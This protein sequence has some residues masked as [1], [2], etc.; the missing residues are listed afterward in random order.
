V[1]A[2]AVP[3]PD[4]TVSRSATEPALVCGR[5]GS[6]SAPGR[7]FWCATC[8]RQ[9]TFSYERTPNRRLRD[10]V[11]GGRSQSGIWSW[12]DLLPAVGSSAITLGEGDTPLLPSR[13]AGPALRLE[14]LFLKVEGTNPSGSFKDRFQAVSISVALHQ[15]FRS[16]FC[17]STGNHGVACATYARRAGLDCVVLLHEEAPESF[18]EACAVLG[19]TVARV[20]AS[21]RDDL[22]EQLFADG[23]FPATCMAPFPIP[24][25]YGIEG[26][27]TIAY[28]VTRD[29]TREIDA[30]IVPV[31]AG[32]GYAGV[33]RGYRDLVA[34]GALDRPPRIIATQPIGADPLVRA[35]AAGEDFVPDLGE[36]A[37]SIALS[38][39]E[40][41]SSQM[42]R[43]VM[44]EVGGDAIA[45]TD[46][47]ILRAA[48]LLADEGLLV[49]VASSASVAAAGV[50]VEEGRLKRDAAIVALLTASGARWPRPSSYQFAGRILRG[51]A[52]DLRRLIL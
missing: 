6:R 31:G 12:G 1:P 32:D 42:S 49:D 15:G 4:V 7:A 52:A 38:I 3:T 8:G 27:R 46:D 13:V 35:T 29:A 48:A 37:P 45:V 21:E 39:R 28:E 10:L 25:P 26:Y 34:V 23:W 11:E 44:R 40:R 36:T 5:C 16:V 51:R 41:E 18:A 14:S 30:M 19:A 33:A 2:S 20:P 24:N 9:G 50:L 47:A 17:V 43:R 22:M